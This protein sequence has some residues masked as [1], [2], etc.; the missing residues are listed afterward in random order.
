[1]TIMKN[2]DNRVPHTQHVLV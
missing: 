1:M 2:Y